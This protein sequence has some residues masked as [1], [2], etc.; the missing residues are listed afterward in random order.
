VV[1][2]ETVEQDLRRRC[3]ERADEMRQFLED[4]EN[5]LNEEDLID[6]YRRRLGDKV[7]A[8]LEELGEHD[9]YP[10]PHLKSYQLAA[11]ANPLSAYAIRNLAKTLGTIGHKRDVGTVEKRAAVRRLL[12]EAQACG[13][14]LEQEY[15]YQSEGITHDDLERW[16]DKTRDFIK[17]AFGNQEAATFMNNHGV[18]IDEDRYVALDIRYQPYLM[19]AR[20][21]RLQQLGKEAHRLPIEDNFDPQKWEGRFSLE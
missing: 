18:P 19:E 13:Q 5:S 2:D 16:V 3:R 1:Q 6:L 20:F 10:P 12:G 21:W 11:N 8:L 7:S 4:H 17:D 14:H 15:Y 9:L